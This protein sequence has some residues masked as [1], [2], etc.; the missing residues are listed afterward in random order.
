[1]SELHHD[2]LFFSA[3]RT[4]FDTNPDGDVVLLVHGFPDNNKSFDTITPALVEAGHR[5]VAPLMRGYEPTSRPVDA[6]TSDYTLTE[7]AGDVA[8]WIDELDAGP[9]H[10]VGHDWGAAIG[11][12]VGAITPDRVKSLTVMAVPHVG[13]FPEAIRKVPS[14][15]IKSWYMTFFQLARFSNA[16]VRRKD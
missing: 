1:M 2:S 12:L 11:Y 13:R 10:L 6:G 7:L 9:V 16:V 8:T 3:K 4:G 5:V 14:Q 15:I